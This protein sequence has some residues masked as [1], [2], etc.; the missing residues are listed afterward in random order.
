MTLKARSEWLTRQIIRVAMRVAP[1]ARVD[2]AIAMTREIDA[3]A[4]QRDALRWAL[5]CLK[6]SCHERLK[7]MRLTDLWPVRWGMA[8]WMALLAVETLGSAGITLAYKFGLHPLSAHPNE[9]L[10]KVTPLW[11]P[12][13]TLAIGLTFVL[14]MVLILK[15]SR[16]ALEAVAIPFVLMLGLVAIRFGRPESGDLQ[17]L[18]IAYERS[19]AVLVWP[20]AG[21]ALT[22]LMCW[23]LW[24]D[25]QP[26]AN[27]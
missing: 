21:L 9:Q 2:W 27:R 18:A 25:R 10:L 7:S 6:A 17:S 11:E 3:I 23:A 22:T 19:P 20:V 12:M 16:A 24:H 26:V 5:G 13:A 8:L 14:A 15:R 1:R 4:G